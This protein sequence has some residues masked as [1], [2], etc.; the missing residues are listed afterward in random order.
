MKTTELSNVKRATARVAPTLALLFFFCANLCAQVTIGDL[1][2]PAAGALLDLNS[3]IGNKGGLLLSNVTITNLDFIPEGNPDVFPGIIPATADSNLNLRGAM[4][5]NDGKNGTTVPAGIYIWNGYCWTKDGRLNPACL[6]VGTGSFGG[7]TRF[8]IA[9]TDG[10]GTNACGTAASRTSQKTDFSLTTPQNGLLGGL[11]PGFTFSG[12][13]VYTFTP[14][15]DVSRVRFD[16]IDESGLVIDRIVP[17]NPSYATGNNI[18]SARV[19]VYYR[20]SLNTD[21]R[22]LTR[23]NALKVKLYAVYNSDAV[24]GT[25]ANDKSVELAVTLQDCHSCGAKTVNG[26][27]L[28]FMCHNLGADATLNPFVWNSNGNY[29]DDDIKGYLYQWGRYSD[30]HQLRN[31]SP[32]GTQIATASVYNAAVAAYKT[33]NTPIP[34]AYTYYFRNS[35]NGVGSDWVTDGTTNSDAVLYRWGSKVNSN[36]S[37]TAKGPNDPCPEGWKVPSQSQWGSIFRGGTTTDAPGTATANTWTWNNGY[38]VGDALYLPA[39]GARFVDINGLQYV[40]SVSDYWSSTWS[41]VSSKSYGSD[42]NSANVLPA[43]SGWRGWGMSVRCVS[44]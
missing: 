30:G 6:P 18:S 38:K 34:T 1:T 42:N 15:T 35:V 24:Y 10:N 12:V 5:Y 43:Y 44:E 41:D 9:Y 32:T 13:Q 14:T 37:T 36:T 8:D 31:S 11:A 4:V 19:T 21:L 27:W 7:K 39:G 3:P 16:Y 2:E 33:N 29:V 28:N 20:E 22:G 40:G 25:A 23:E 26:G 17:E